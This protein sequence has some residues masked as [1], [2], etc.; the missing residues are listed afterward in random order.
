MQKD[1]NRRTDLNIKEEKEKDMTTDLEKTRNKE[2]LAR[3]ENIMAGSGISWDDINTA[4]GTNL[5]K[6]IV[7]GKADDS[8]LQAFCTVMNADVRYLLMER[9][10]WNIDPNDPVA[11][12]KDGKASMRG[13]D[14][15][16]MWK[17]QELDL[18]IEQPAEGSQKPAETKK[19]T[20]GHIN[21]VSPEKPEK[22]KRKPKKQYGVKFTEFE[23]NEIVQERLREFV[24]R[25]GVNFHAVNSFIGNRGES[26]ASFA[27]GKQVPKGMTATLAW[28]CGTTSAYLTGKSDSKT[29]SAS[30]VRRPVME[31]QTVMV[32]HKKLIGHGDDLI[33]KNGMTKDM[34]AWLMTGDRLVTDLF[35]KRIAASIGCKPRQL[36]KRNPVMY[37]YDE[38]ILG[39][40]DKWKAEQE[41]KGQRKAKRMQKASGK[42]SEGTAEAE[43]GSKEKTVDDAAGKR[44][45]GIKRTGVHATGETVSNECKDVVNS[46]DGAD[47]MPSISAGMSNECKDD[48]CENY[49]I[50][51]IPSMGTDLADDCRDAVPAN[52]VEND[53][54][55]ALEEQDTE[56]GTESDAPEC[57][58]D[59]E[60]AGT[61]TKEQSMTLDGLFDALDQL[62]AESLD[63]VDDYIKSLRIMRNAIKKNRELRDKLIN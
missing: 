51:V 9:D 54:G 39:L 14:I 12:L 40:Y 1:K 8:E 33:K 60:T 28:M 15:S 56:T 6:D 30:H 27:T 11:P 2:L 57:C 49:G 61:E 58:E 4:C 52:N 19:A 46:N 62:P 48:A 24:N 43:N 13:N 7:G 20:E 22:R 37:K 31:G 38:P 50:D 32:N 5:R 3:C 23:P 63:A 59:K 42:S 25:N 34:A 53:D 47:A 44:E 16:S 17:Q 26:I 41:L 35:L 21:A 29:K 55:S 36:M 18:G 45:N 10:S